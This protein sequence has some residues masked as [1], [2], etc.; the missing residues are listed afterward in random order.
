MNNHTTENCRKPLKS[1]KRPHNTS[2]DIVCYYCAETGHF[3]K[4]YPVWKTSTRGLQ[5][6][7][8]RKSTTRK[9][10][11]QALVVTKRVSGYAENFD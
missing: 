3:K 5:P 9:R 11:L 1:S 8:L 2:Y 4:L 7:Q 6:S 10:R